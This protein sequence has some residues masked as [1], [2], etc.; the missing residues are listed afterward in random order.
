M[1]GLVL[2]ALLLGLSMEKGP[3]ELRFDHGSVRI[4][5]GCE[6]QI[7]ASIDAVLGVVNCGSFRIDVF[8]PPGDP[9]EPCGYDPRPKCARNIPGRALVKLQDARQLSLCSAEWAKGDTR[10]ALTVKPGSITFWAKPQNPD[11]VA[12]F[13]AIATSYRESSK[14]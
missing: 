11:E 3:A 13:F 14:Q 8:A 5:E 9:C 2:T 7:A 4:P 10:V 12:I 6:G 1:S